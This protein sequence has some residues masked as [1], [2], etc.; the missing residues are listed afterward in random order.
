MNL[1]GTTIEQMNQFK[2]N[3]EKKKLDN[4]LN[5]KIEQLRVDMDKNNTPTDLRKTKENELREEFNQKWQNSG[6]KKSIAKD[7]KLLKKEIEKK[8]QLMIEEQKAFVKD[9]LKT[10]FESNKKSPVFMVG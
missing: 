6:K 7:I 4:E 1:V 8:R 3:Y 9:I 2:Q 10:H 5:K